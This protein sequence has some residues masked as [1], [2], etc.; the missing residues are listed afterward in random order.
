MVPAFMDEAHQRFLSILRPKKALKTS[1]VQA[2]AIGDSGI[3]SIS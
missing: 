1:T 2:F 3:E